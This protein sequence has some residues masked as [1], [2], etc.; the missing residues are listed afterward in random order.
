MVCGLICW[1]DVVSGSICWL[2]V[3]RVLVIVVLKWVLSVF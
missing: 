3:L 1:L 2:L